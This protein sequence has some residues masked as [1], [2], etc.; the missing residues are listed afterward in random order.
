MQRGNGPLFPA[1]SFF[2]KEHAMIIAP[3]FFA[4][5]ASIATRVATAV[6]NRRAAQDLAEWD[7]RALKDI[8]L[9]QADVRGAL[10]LPLY[11]DPTML[12]ASLTGRNTGAMVGDVHVSSL[13][14]LE[15]A[16]YHADKTPVCA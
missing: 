12:L 5:L 7:A 14:K 8:G 2:G 1:A 3:G 13:P 11:E 15:M 9:T 6:A 4:L 10:A 16:V